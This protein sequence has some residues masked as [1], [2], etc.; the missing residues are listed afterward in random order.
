MTGTFTTRLHDDGRAIALPP[1]NRRRPANVT[2]IVSPPASC[3]PQA[4]N[5]PSNALFVDGSA[6]FIG[7]EIAQ[8]IWRA[9][10]TRN[11]GEPVDSSGFGMRA[12][13]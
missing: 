11:G 8:A 7:S 12:G 3:Y 10:G 2:T 1:D 6:H 5:P 13:S 4:K 9:L